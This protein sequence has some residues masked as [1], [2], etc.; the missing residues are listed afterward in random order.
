MRAYL[1]YYGYTYDIVEVNSVNKKQI[2]WSSYKKVPILAI[3][4]PSENDP[5]KYEEEIMVKKMIS[6]ILSEYE[7]WNYFV[8]LKKQLNDS[9]VIISALETYRLDPSKSLRQISTYFE[10]VKIDN[11][12]KANAEYMNKYFVMLYNSKT[13]DGKDVSDRKYVDKNVIW[14]KFFKIVNNIHCT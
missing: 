2:D 14:L 1:D 3:Q 6:I 7:I 12:P 5:E 8:I 9:T 13:S 10:P 4:I 11:D